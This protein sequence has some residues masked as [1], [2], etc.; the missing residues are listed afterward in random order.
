MR[1]SM[2][3]VYNLITYWLLSN[4]SLLVLINDPLSVLLHG[5][6]PP[7]HMPHGLFCQLASDS[8]T[9]TQ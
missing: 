6:Q 4:I 1:C 5:H 2:S 8:A 7:V 9:S 3:H